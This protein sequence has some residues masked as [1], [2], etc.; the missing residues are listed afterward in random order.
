M[1]VSKVAYASAAP[2]FLPAKQSA[3]PLSPTSTPLVLPLFTPPASGQS[4]LAT[5]AEDVL[6]FVNGGLETLARQKAGSPAVANTF[7]A[8][9]FAAI[10]GIPVGKATLIRRRSGKEVEATVTLTHGKEK[11]AHLSGTADE[12]AIYVRNKK[13]GSTELDLEKDHVWVR[14][15]EAPGNDRYK[16]IGTNLHQIAVEHS[17]AKGLM[18]KVALYSLSDAVGFHYKSGFRSDKRGENR[19]I[20]RFVQDADRRREKT[21]DY[22]T[23]LDMALTKPQI[24]KWKKRIEKSPILDGQRLNR[25]A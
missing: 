25:I 11:Y 23:S 16:L 14:Y 5:L 6:T 7:T 8:L 17:L 4:K 20:A 2:Q 9:R 10:E 18:G 12:Y 22:D 19:K 24:E 15:M 3:A 21:P 1:M 13:V